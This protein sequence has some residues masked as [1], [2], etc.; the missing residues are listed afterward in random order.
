MA[1]ADARLEFFDDLDRLEGSA[2]ATLEA[3]RATSPETRRLVESFNAAWRNHRGERLRWR[4]AFSLPQTSAPVVDAEPDATL[5]DVRQRLD[6]L[7]NRYA[8]GLPT[9]GRA[10]AVDAFARL[11]V[12]VSKQRT[13]IDLW[14]AAEEA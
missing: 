4:A 3:L 9:L 1:R 5:P 11:M 7:M 10:A 8:D 6:D 14:I 13:V 12:A 2:A